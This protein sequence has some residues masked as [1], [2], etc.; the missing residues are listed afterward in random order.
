MK[1]SKSVFEAQRT[2]RFGTANPER[3]RMAFWEWMVR[4]DPERRA[5]LRAG[6][7]RNG[8]SAWRARDEFELGARD[9]GPIWCFDRMGATATELPDGRIVCVAGEHEDYYDPDFYIYNDVVVLG[10]D[11]EVEIYG[12]PREVFPPTD[13]HTATLLDDRIVLIG[14]VGYPE[15]REPGVTP[16]YTLDI[17]SFRIDPVKVSGDAPSWLHRHDARLDDERG[18]ITVTGG[19]VIEQRDGESMRFVPSIEAYELSVADGVWRRTTDRRW[20]IYNVVRDDSGMF[21][22]EQDPEL[23]S[24]FPKSLA[25]TRIPGGDWR[26]ARIEVLGVPVMYEIGLHEI[27]IVVEGELPAST[28]QVLVDD[29]RRSLEA[30]F[31][32]N[33]RIE[34]P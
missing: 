26:T 20:P 3:M 33:C 30:Q 17:G 5:G 18:V 16:V 7:F 21:V 32:I 6:R 22:L 24:L 12:Y 13:F 1:I 25:Y 29:V 34:G 2:P 15:D 14:C 8:N 23:E 31:E 27:I 10:P 9:G 4:G 11:D 19:L 28:V